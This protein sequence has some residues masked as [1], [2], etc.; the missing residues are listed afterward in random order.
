VKI[1]NTTYLLLL[2]AVLGRAEQTPT[3]R[4]IGQEPSLPTFFI[5]NRGLTDPAI[6]YFIQ[7]PDLRAGF[8][9]DSAVFQLHDLSLR[10]RFDGA[11]PRV[12]V[13]AEDPLPARANFLIGNRPEQWQ[14]GLPLY[15]KILYRNLYPG[16][17]MTYGGVGHRIKSEFV[18][19]PGADPNRIRLEYSGAEQLEIDARGDLLVRGQ[20]MEVREEAPVVYQETAGG[21]VEIAA[22][23]RLDDRTLAFEIGPYDPSLPLVID[24]VLSYATYVGGGGLSA[25]TGLALDPS[26][27]LYVAGWTE[28]LDFN[29]VVPVQASN[30]G[31]VDVFVAKLNAAGTA[32]VYATYIGGRGDDRAAAIA[33]DSSGEAYVTGATSSTNFP[34]VAP[35]RSTLGGGRDAF[36]LKLSAFGNRMIYSTY[37]GGSNTDAGNAIAIDSLGNAYIAGDTASNDFPVSGAAQTTLGGGTDAFVTKLTPSGVISF[38]TFLGGSGTEHA[39]GMAVDLSGNVYVAGG[40]TSTNFPVVTPLQA[41]SGGS[42]DAFLTKLSSTGSQ[43]VY[44]TYFGGSGGAVGTPEQA[45]AVAVDSS[46]NAY[47]AGITN[48][49]NFPVTGGA[50]QIVFNGVEDAFVAKVNAAGNGLFYSTYLGGTGFDSANALAIDSSGNAYIAGYTSSASLAVVAPIQASFKGLYDAFISEVNAQG[51]GLGF[52]TYYGGTGSDAANAIVVDAAGNIFVGGQTSSFDLPLQTPIQPSNLGGSVGWVARMGVTAA[53]PQVPS[54]N[55]VTPNSGSGNTVTFSAQFSH[56]AGAG[57]IVT[58]ALLVNTTASSDFACQA[59]Y[60]PSTNLFALANDVAATGSSPVVPNGGGAQ[61]SQCTLNGAGSFATLSGN[62]LTLNVSL[63]FL[64]AFAGAKT[65]YISAADN[66]TST[67][68]VAR[69]V[70]TVAIPQPMPTADSVSPN[71]S[72]GSSQTFTF[73]F[74]DTQNPLNLTSMSMLFNTTSGSFTNACYI[75]Y[76]RV[77]GTVGLFSDNAATTSTKP[78]A[79]GVV[80]QN[81]QCSVGATVVT[82]SGFANII[83]VSITFK[84]AFSGLKNIY[85]YGS[86]NGIFVTGWVQRGTYSASVGGMP[87]A[88]SAVPS[89]GSGNKQRFS[90]TVSD[91]GGAGFI[92][93]AAVLISASSDTNNACLLVYDRTA[94]TVAL[95]YDNPNNGHTP[96]VLG[97]STIATNGQC[98]LYGANT[99]VISGITA[100]EITLDLSFN[101]TFSGTKNLYLLASEGGPIN[102][103]FVIV[104]TWT[105]TGGSPT[106]DSVNPSSGAGTL[107]T[108]VFTVSDSASAANITGIGVLFTTGAPTNTTGA[109]YVTYDRASATVTLYG[110]DGVSTQSKG[111]GSAATMQNSQCAVGYT[112]PNVSGNSFLFILQ[113]LFKS[114]FAGPKTVYLEANEP[115]ASSGWV[116]RGAWTA[117]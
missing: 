10:V 57:A 94:N 108:F 28:A 97:A 77:A 6:R 64:P 42:Q 40:T 49:S 72:S 16:I 62:N 82:V 59:T 93:G 63:T 73:V 101:A 69:G 105:V 23:Y 112:G 7:T 25:V 84:P 9:A 2:A 27:S 88:N 53:P 87:V 50:F 65:V 67:G 54:A 113:V 83:T 100:V 92:H 58:A 32:Y 12:Q 51:N 1:R 75:V 114:S 8:T 98:T 104:G 52:S 34:L 80:L 35:V 61:N 37:L 46:G 13:E 86:E 81:S 19:A 110:D 71:G 78:V 99:T 111:V 70:W 103:G 33:V 41:V 74:S 79:S 11:N 89:S 31:G 29:I 109:C 17:D 115:G 95:S 68:L 38:S 47:I 14:T 60:N 22:S 106:A 43:I 96:V 90:F 66:A 48:S 45:N 56:P 18:V 107:P 21:R 85:M 117:Q 76:D 39:G 3:P 4:H 15:R 24:P 91:P 20:H 116:A 55:S 26:G 5:P 44:S 102:S 30:Q 36:A